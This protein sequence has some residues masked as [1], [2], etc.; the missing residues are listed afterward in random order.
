M[1]NKKAVHIRARLLVQAEGLIVEL[2][3][4]EPRTS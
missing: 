2:R 3:G 4:V 1:A